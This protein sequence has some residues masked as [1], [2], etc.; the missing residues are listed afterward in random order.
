MDGVDINDNVLGQPNAL[1]IEDAIEE[2][3]VLTRASRRNTAASA[4]ASS[5]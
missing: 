3:Q 1:F 4:A 5:T 2:V